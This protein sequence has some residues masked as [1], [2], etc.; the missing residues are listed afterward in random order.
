M[1]HLQERRA[2]G[3]PLIG[4]IAAMAAA[5]CG[6][7]HEAVPNLAQSLSQT[8]QGQRSPGS[9]SVTGSL[10]TPRVAP[11]AVTLSNGKVLIAGGLDN[12]NHAIASAELYDP[13]SA[14]WSKTAGMSTARVQATMTLLQNKR[15]LVAGGE[16]ATGLTASAEIYNH[17][18]HRW[19]PT[20]SM[21]TPRA[22]HTATLLSDGR[23][24]VA[25]GL[26][27]DYSGG[28]VSAEIYDPTSGKWS[29]TGSM[30]TP[31]ESQSATLLATGGVLISGGNVDL[32]DGATGS[33]EVYH[34]RS[35]KWTTTGRMMTSRS[36]QIS[37]T[38]ADGSAIVSGGDYGNSVGFNPLAMTDRYN[39][40]TNR[41][42]PTGDMRVALGAVP[43]VAGRANHTATELADGRVLVAGGFGYISD[44]TQTVILQTAEIF[45]PSSATWRLTGNMNQPRAQHAAVALS[46]G[47]VLVAG[48]YDFGPPLASAEIFSAKS[49]AVS[50]PDAMSMHPGFVSPRVAHRARS[51]SARVHRAVRPI[52]VLLGR[53]SGVSASSVG[54]WTTTAPMHV[55]RAFQPA[56]LLQNGKVLVEGC[57]ALGSGGKTAELYDPAKGKWA[58]TGSMHVA[59]CGHSAVMLD[60]GRVLVAGGASDANVW[61]SMEI[62]D[63]ATHRW[64]LAGNL[65]STRSDAALALLPNGTVLAPAGFAVNAIPRDSADLYS[66]ASHSSAA[67]PSLN[68]SRWG[69]SADVLQ[70]GQVLVEGGITQDN[71]TTPTCEL[72][73]PAANAWTFT[74]STI[75]QESNV[76][77]LLNAGQVLATTPSQQYDP[78]TGL[79]TQTTGQLNIDRINNTLTVLA[80]G[81]VLTAGGCTAVSSCE[82][83]LQSEVYDPVTQLWSLDAS[84]HAARESASATRLP[85]GRVLVAGGFG[86]GFAQLTSAEL[87]TPAG[88]R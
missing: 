5:G 58:M 23:V 47:R 86:Q 14:R 64:S 1:L 28:I 24:L 53:R 61:S 50:P 21:M 22:N 56:T 54:T 15:V 49:Q 48:G 40:K 55:G 85:D 69:Y 80:D 2:I 36:S 68:L 6:Q 4:L 17:S 82:L 35:G 71:F 46:D 12:N 62:Y 44:F 84:I 57:D 30:S 63:P 74:G 20:G 42:S 29:L 60:D 19:S 38:L 45:D 73:D 41:W 34:P 3:V 88:R 33:A 70:N 81:R 37:V 67:T 83:V 39:P 52:G 77:V 75:G 51:I 16:T 18:A 10:R 59:R 7:I 78:A 72:Y 26:S 13:M 79:W 66:A 11:M 65:N 87:Y 43:K 76:S 25:G 9:W 8:G 32:L 31:R 27:S